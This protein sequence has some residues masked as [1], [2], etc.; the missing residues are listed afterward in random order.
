MLPYRQRIGQF[1]RDDGSALR[2]VESSSLWG[3]PAVS[4]RT[5]RTAA[6]Y[7][8]VAPAAR[9]A[10]TAAAWTARALGE[11]G[12]GGGGVA[13]DPGAV[14][15]AICWIGEARSSVR[16]SNTSFPADRTRCSA[17]SRR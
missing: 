15:E 12:Q 5:S 9:S 17:W 16:V 11:Q 7:S 13:G 4:A 2:D 14:Y 8:Q 1:L 10:C 6:I 3:P